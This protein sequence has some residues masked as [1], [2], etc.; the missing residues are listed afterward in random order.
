[1]PQTNFLLLVRKGISFQD[2]LAS[3]ALRA[4]S[5]IF[6]TLSAQSSRYY[7]TALGPMRP[8]LRY[9]PL[10]PRAVS[11]NVFGSD[12]R[13]VVFVEQSESRRCLM[14][15]SHVLIFDCRLEPGEKA[16]VRWPVSGGFLA[17]RS[18]G[19]FRLICH[20]LTDGLKSRIRSLR[21]CGTSAT[22]AGPDVRC[23][24]ATAR[25]IH[26]HL[27]KDQA[28]KC[29]YSTV[30][31]AFRAL[32]SKDDIWDLA[33]DQITS[34]NRKEATAFLR[35][36]TSLPKLLDWKRRFSTDKS[37]AKNKYNLDETNREAVDWMR[38]VQNGHVRTENLDVALTASEVEKILDRIRRGGRRNSNKALLC[39]PNQR[40]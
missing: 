35:R 3:V 1:M 27:D 7:V 24:R 14:T 12:I 29:S 20:D 26:L 23:T 34:L 38:M 40:P 15:P 2:G 33:L 17:I 22:N 28:I 16:S 25:D 9:R 4:S 5:S 39:W 13:S 18:N 36:I 10:G 19:F 21:R 11:M 8:C 30:C 6:S 32:R 31:R 37:A